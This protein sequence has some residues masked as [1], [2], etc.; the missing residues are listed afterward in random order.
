MI[1]KIIH[2]CWFGK[3]AKPQDV[4]KNIKSWEYFNPDFKIKEWNEENFNINL[5]PYVSEAYQNKKYAFVSDVAR[6]YALVNE[7]GIYLDTD[8]ECI[9]PFTEDFLNNQ[10][11]IGF[12]ESEKIKIGTA[13]IGSVKN[14]PFWIEVLKYYST[15]KFITKN[16]KLNTETNTTLLTSILVRHGLKLNNLNQCILGISIYPKDYFSPKNYRSN[17]I[18]V[19]DNTI[20]IH[21]YDATWL[22]YTTKIKIKVWNYL[23]TH[24]NSLARFI[25]FCVKKK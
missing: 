3:K 18:I 16:N 6:I 19:T 17:K 15:Q 9:K 11:F 23:F 14:Y 8:V 21:N 10:S 4:I 25:Q 7:G 22:P 5:C 20:C 13:T 1:P 12:E 2:Y 24:F